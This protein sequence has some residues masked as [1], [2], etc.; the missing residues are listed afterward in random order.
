MQRWRILVK[1]KKAYL[2]I[3]YTALW[4]CYGYA[5]ELCIAKR[6]KKFVHFFKQKKV[7]LNSQTSCCLNLRVRNQAT[8]YEAEALVGNVGRGGVQVVTIFLMPKKKPLTNK[9]E[10]E[11]WSLLVALSGITPVSSVHW[12]H[13]V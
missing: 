11:K 6:K 12:G 9:A 10:K 7:L 13:F 2:Y 5:I 4:K 8:C 1:E 3:F